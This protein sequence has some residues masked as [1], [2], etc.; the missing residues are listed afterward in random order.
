M[1]RFHFKEDLILE[2]GDVLKEPVIAYHTYGQLNQSKD[3]VIWICHALTANS[4]AKAWWPGLVGD[5]LL[6]DTS[7][8]FIVCANI[9]GSCYGTTGPADMNPHTG[10]P[11]HHEFPFITIRDMVKAHRL[12]KDHLE[13]QKIA[14]LAG[15]SMGGYQALEWALMEK[16]SISR[17]FII[18]SSARE[19]AWGIG[20]HTAQR[21]AIETD[22]TWKQPDA[23]AGRQ[24]LKTARAIGMITYRSYESFIQ[25]QGE[26]DNE[27]IDDFKASSYIHY[28]GEKLATRFTAYSYWYLTKAM[29]THNLARGGKS[30]EKALASV[31]AKTLVIGITSDLLCPLPEQKFLAEHI[32][33]ATFVSI[34][35]LFGHDG[36]LVETEA[37]AGAVYSWW[38]NETTTHETS[39]YKSHTKAS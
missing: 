15:G 37:I 33:D 16:E 18:A 10:K 25:K 9:L 13:I 14:L 38:K 6:F 3:N 4:D 11:Y 5:G 29:D 35:S 32:P 20:I 39:H 31:T 27:R 34:D 23:N 12:L 21:M 22:P 30:M 26:E 19:T 7:R 36:F 1:Q 28:Q 17:L 8:Y 2:N 24:G